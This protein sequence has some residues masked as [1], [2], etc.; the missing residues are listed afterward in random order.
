MTVSFA[1]AVRR[2]VVTTKQKSKL[3]FENSHQLKMSSIPSAS[4]SSSQQGS[5]SS[6]ETN[7]STRTCLADILQSYQCPFEGNPELICAYYER[8]T[9]GGVCPFG[10]QLTAA[11]IGSGLK[12]RELPSYLCVAHLLEECINPLT[13][14]PVSQLIRCTDGLHL[15][16]AELVDGKLLQ[17]MLASEVLDGDARAKERLGEVQSIIYSFDAV[18]KDGSHS[19]TSSSASDDSCCSICHTP[20]IST[21]IFGLLEGCD[22][23]FCVGCILAWHRNQPSYDNRRSCPNCRVAFTRVLLWPT[24]KLPA[25]WS[26]E[27][28]KAIFELQSCCAGLPAGEE[29]NG[30]NLQEMLERLTTTAA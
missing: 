26:A 7:T 27:H 29:V 6:T 22:H 4:T 9:E 30:D 1:A 17:E 13:K 18:E 23:A 3:S 20:F 16:A 24:P 15:T 21:P 2:R 11:I 25:S 8:H 10:H 12:P 14:G 28:K 5:Q 19:E